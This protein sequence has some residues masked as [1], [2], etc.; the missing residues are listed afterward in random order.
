M[1]A[2]G[3]LLGALHVIRLSRFFDREALTLFDLPRAFEISYEPSASM[4]LVT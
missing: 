3:S 4:T 1:I 2:F